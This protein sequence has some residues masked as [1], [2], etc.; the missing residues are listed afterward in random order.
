M[1]ACVQDIIEVL[2]TIAPF[3]LAEKWDNSG[4]QAGDRTWPVK[5]ILLA[6]DVTMAAMATAQKSKCDMLITHH[7]LVISPE[8]SIDFGTMPGAAIEVAAREKIAVLSAHTNLDKARDGLNDYFAEQLGIQC[9]SP[10]YSDDSGLGD[11][12]TGIGRLGRLSQPMSIEQLVRMIKQKL[13]IPALRVAGR[14]DLEVDAVALCTGSGGSLTGHFLNSSAQVFITGDL[15]YHE[16]RDIEAKGK[17]VIDVGHF[18]SEHIVIGLLRNRL[19][20]SLKSLGCEIEIQDFK[21]E[22]D[23]F[24]II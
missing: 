22:K 17:T 14:L 9:E 12:R 11:S 15:K 23:P 13:N 24:K 1:T 20:P 6:L 10:F 19:T 16:A 8:K 5:R 18:A 4:L 3:E 2:N 7:P 21:E